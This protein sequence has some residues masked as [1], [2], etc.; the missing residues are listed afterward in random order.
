MIISLHDYYNVNKKLYI[1]K[2]TFRMSMSISVAVSVSSA[3]ASSAVSSAISSSAISMS[4]VTGLAIGGILA[5]V[6]LIV[7]L[8]SQEILSASSLWNKRIS[9]NFLMISLPLLIV[10]FAIVSFQILAILG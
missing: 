1:Q 10:F 5:T 2:I 9:R 7:L 3:S 6:L 8:S 4:S